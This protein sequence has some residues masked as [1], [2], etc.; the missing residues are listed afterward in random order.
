MAWCPYRR[1]VS[2]T[3][4][5][6]VHPGP[7]GPPPTSDMVWVPPASGSPGFWIDACPVT[8]AE[9]AVFVDDSGYRAGG[10][11]GGHPEAPAVGVAWRDVQAYADWAGK[12]LPTE[13]EWVRAAFDGRSRPAGMPGRAK[14]ALAGPYPVATHPPNRYGLYDTVGNVWQWTADWYLPHRKVIRGGGRRPDARAGQR[15]ER[16]GPRVGFRCVV[17][18]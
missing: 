3:A 18:L 12:A 10:W 4:F 14:A 1:A 7:D 16:S 8:N 11:P 2:Q 13:A 15:V 6:T 9:F 17:R 5:I